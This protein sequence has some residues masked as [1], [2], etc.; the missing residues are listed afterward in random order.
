MRVL[1]LRPRPGGISPPQL[2]SIHR[3]VLFS[4]SFLLCNLHKFRNKFSPRKVL[5]QGPKARYNKGTK[6]HQLLTTV[7]SDTLTPEEKQK[8]MKEKF[9]IVTTVKMKGGLAKMCNLSDYIEEKSIEKGIRKKL[10]EQVQKKLYK[11]KT[12]EQIADELETEIEEILPIY[13]RL[14]AETA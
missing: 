5:A 10:E 6:L 8:E 14:L 9:D 3:Y 12:L 7:L 11:N 13:N 4:T 2:I 1:A